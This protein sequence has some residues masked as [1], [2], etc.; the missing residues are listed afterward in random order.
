MIEFNW[1]SLLSTYG[2]PTEQKGISECDLGRTFPKY[3]EFWGK[4]IF[5]NRDSSDPSKLRSDIKPEIEDIF[6]NH[7]GIFY[8]LT[9]S[10]YQLKNLDVPV[11]DVAT[12]FYHLGAVV[13]LTERVFLATLRASGNLRIDALERDDF[14]GIAKD[15]WEQEYQ[16]RF[17]DFSKRYRPVSINLHNV[18]DLFEQFVPGNAKFRK[19][20]NSIRHYRNTLIHS[21]P[22]LKL[23]IDDKVYIP[24]E[25]YLHHYATARWSS[26][27]TKVNIHHYGRAEEVIRDLTEG[28]TNTLNESWDSL[29][30]LVGEIIPGQDGVNT[31]AQ[32]VE[33]VSSSAT[34]GRASGV[35]YPEESGEATFNYN[36]L[37]RKSEPINSGGTAEYIPLEDNKPPTK[38]LGYAVDNKHDPF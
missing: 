27:R 4:Y 25:K 33:M 31:L 9:T 20:S 8:H 30:A 19:I 34:M 15:F 22:P 1:V 6:N 21:L 10:L 12:P 32:S 5:P 11:L 3:A 2:D 29:I 23:K 38:P 26:E 36:N 7:Y 16:D 35:S 24:Q 37:T 13:D 18:S 28:L 17:A 14:D